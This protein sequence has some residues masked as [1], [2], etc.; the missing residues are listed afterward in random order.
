MK[1]IEVFVLMC[2]ILAGCSEEKRWDCFQRMGDPVTETRQPGTFRE[3]YLENRIE[4]TLVQDNS[5]S[6]IVEAGEH[7]I[8]KVFTEVEGNV[9]RIYEK[10]K[11][12]FL[13]TYK[14]GIKVTVHVPSLVRITHE[15]TGTIQ[16]SGT[17]TLDTLDIITQSAGDVYMNINANKV[18][19]H[20][21]GTGDIYLSG[22]SQD[23]ACYATGNGFLEA[24]ALQTGYTWLY[25]NCTGNAHVRANGLL[26]AK[27]HWTG[28]VYFTGGPTVLSEV[29][30][31]GKLLEY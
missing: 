2:M 11:C 29:L 1:R 12:D 9:L 8:D 14:R 31:S 25:W 7:I 27:L 21:I 24:D 26:I 16:S 13:R 22:S 19:T 30:G 4:V 28:D 5:F 18:L 17:F 3:I 20:M 6:V 23:H 10:N 15:G